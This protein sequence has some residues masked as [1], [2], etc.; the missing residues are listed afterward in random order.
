MT[1]RPFRFGVSSLVTGSRVAWQAKARL[2]ALVSAAEVTGLRLGT[3]LLNTGLYRPAVLAREVADTDQLTEGRL[4]LG[5]GTGY[6]EDDFEAA[7]LPFP[8]PGE[9]VDHLAH[10]VSELRRLFASEKQVP[11]V[12]QRPTPPLFLGGNGNRLLRLAAREADI[13]GFLGHLSH[14]ELRERVGFLR[15]AAGER[16][17]AMELHMFVSAVA[18]AAMGGGEPNL[19]LVRQIAPGASDEQLL[20]LPGVLTGSAQEIADTLVEYR[21]TYG[22]TYFSVVETHM[23][24]FA[25]VIGHLR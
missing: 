18:V 7:E 23:N 13:V 24:D 21:E 14:V 5:L 1:A 19:N 22:I 4:E 2:A 6:A 10:T 20:E 11:A 3:L 15:A 12:R 16:F 9:R 25:K 8:S 17:D